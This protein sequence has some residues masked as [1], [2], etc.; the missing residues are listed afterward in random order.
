M[1]HA[2]VIPMIWQRKKSSQHHV[3]KFKNN[4][5]SS[6]TTNSIP[7][8]RLQVIFKKWPHG[9]SRVWMAL[10]K[11]YIARRTQRVQLH[12]VKIG[13]QPTKAFK[14]LLPKGSQW[15]YFYLKATLN[16]QARNPLVCPLVSILVV[17]VEAL[18]YLLSYKVNLGAIQGME[19]TRH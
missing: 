13:D 10:T 8:Q 1:G 9:I 6:H 12:S 5:K 19:C 15:E 18:R 14:V 17:A 7:K 16:L 2:C 4:T 3:H 11:K